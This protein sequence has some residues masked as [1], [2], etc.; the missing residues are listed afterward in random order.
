MPIARETRREADVLDSFAECMGHE[1]R[2]RI[3]FSLHQLEGGESLHVPRDVLE[4][5]DDRDAF[6]VEIAHNHLPRLDELG[7]VS[8]DREAQVVEAGEGF[9]RIEPLLDVLTDHYEQIVPG[10]D[11]SPGLR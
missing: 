5:E 6:V 9:E 8:W 2:R 4:E 3:L 11:R 10:A 1:Y 7:Y